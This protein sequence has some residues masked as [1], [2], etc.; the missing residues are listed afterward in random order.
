MFV[1]IGQAEK[2]RGRERKGKR[3]TVILHYINKARVIIRLLNNL[4][5]HLELFQ[6]PVGEFNL[7]TWITRFLCDLLPFRVYTSTPGF[8]AE[9]GNIEEKKKTEKYHYL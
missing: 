5:N 7:H 3:K 8:L 4:T 9:K 2:G 6:G 1:F